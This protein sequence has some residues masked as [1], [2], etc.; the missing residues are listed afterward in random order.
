MM[1]YN[2]RTKCPC[3]GHSLGGMAAHRTHW[4]EGYW[5]CHD[6]L[7]MKKGSHYEPCRCV[8]YFGSELEKQL[9]LDKKREQLKNWG[10]NN[11]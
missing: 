1:E 6:D 5:R 7:P 4:E 2:D 3:C 9:G 8:I 11:G 10:K